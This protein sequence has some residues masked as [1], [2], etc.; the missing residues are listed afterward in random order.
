MTPE[1]VAEGIPCG[2]DVGPIV[3]AVESYLEAGFTDVALC[4]VGGG[5]QEGFCDFA[6]RTLLPEL[7]KLS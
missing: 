1:D 6:D 7:P 5:H 4:Q 3:E 2:P